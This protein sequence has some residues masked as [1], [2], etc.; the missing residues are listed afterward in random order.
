MKVGLTATM[1][2]GGKSGVGQYVLSLTRHLLDRGQVDLTVF[3]REEERSLFAF[4]EDRA[5]IVVAGSSNQ[6]P[7]GDIVWHQAVLPFEAKRRRLELLH[8]PSYRR[9]IARASCPVV[10][11]IHD[12]APFHLTDKYDYARMFYG[13]VVVKHL[14]RRQD[15]LI[16][17]SDF[18]A[19]DIQKFYGIPP[20]RVTTIPNGIDHARFH[21]NH[22]KASQY[23]MR[24][25]YALE[26]PY[27]LYVSRLEHPGKNHV[28]LLEAF[29]KFKAASGA[30]WQLVL[31]GGDWHGAE[32]IKKASA[33]SPYRDDIRFLGFV[34][35]AVMGDLYRSAQ[36]MIYPSLFE[37]FGLP[38]AEGMACGT[39]V[40]SSTRGALKEVVSGAALSVNPESVEEMSEKL[41]ALYSSPSLAADL[42]DAGLIRSK[43]FDWANNAAQVEETY[44]NVLTASEPP[45]EK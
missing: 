38:P 19:R 4:A 23:T 43:S 8:V 45:L 14:A 5:A 44:R 1:I 29:S 3:V 24:R 36:A 9:L 20:S 39:P 34:P 10:G 25:E 21:P 30:N 27:I 17:V 32:V 40:I 13:R 35:D 28:R 2:Q 7:L 41:L 11:T 26:K 16:A 37:G 15:H 42:R 33:E 31:G 22:R 12:L 18:T 6:G